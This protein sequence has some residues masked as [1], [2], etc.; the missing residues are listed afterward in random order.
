MGNRHEN[1]SSKE[2]VQEVKTK[3]RK[4]RFIELVMLVLII[5]GVGI[6]VWVV[7]VEIHSLKQ[8]SQNQQRTIDAIDQAVKDITTDNKHN[9]ELI[10]ESNR[11]INCLLDLHIRESTDVSECAP[12]PEPNA[13]NSAQQST[14]PNQNTNTPQSQNQN[15]N[16][17]GQSGGPNEQPGP[18]PPVE[19]LG[20]PVCVPFT[21]VCVRQ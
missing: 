18:N 1:M 19:I 4:A 14:S 5:V 9:T 11:L 2:L 17:A 21:E 8:Q 6:A 3:Q 20:I 12:E 7:G 13:T 15:P 16:P 10:L